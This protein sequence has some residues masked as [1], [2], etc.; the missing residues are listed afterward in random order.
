MEEKEGILQKRWTFQYSKLERISHF[1]IH[2]K[3]AFEAE[4]H[5][6]AIPSHWELAEWGPWLPSSWE[7][8]C[9]EL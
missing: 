8:S 5:R 4:T 1:A 3:R 7:L 2:H 9:V 6:V